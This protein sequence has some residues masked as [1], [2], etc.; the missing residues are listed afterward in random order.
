MSHMNS[1]KKTPKKAINIS[2]NC[3]YIKGK[4]IEY[5]ESY[6]L[7]DEE[8]M[9]KGYKEMAKINLNLSQEGI[10]C[11]FTQLSEYEQWLCGV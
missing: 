11:E 10:E 1:N 7:D 2:K 3:K 8:L 9:I 5:R 4:V 6:I